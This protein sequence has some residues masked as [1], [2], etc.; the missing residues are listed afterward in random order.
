MADLRPFLTGFW[1]N[2][3]LGQE[4]SIS[5]TFIYNGL[6]SFYGL[7]KLD[8]T[9]E[10]FEVLYNLS[11]GIE[12]LMKI[13][14][15]LLEHKDSDDIDAFENSLRTHSHLELLGRIKKHVDVPLA[16][17]HHDF[18]ALLTKF[19]I[20]LRYDRFLL[21]SMR[22]LD[23]ERQEL[24]D[25]LEKHLK[26]EFG[27]RDSI[28]GY[29]N[30]PRYKKF[31]RGIV[32]KIS[33]ALYKVVENRAHELNVYTY[34]MR[35]GSKAETVFLGKADIPTEDVLWKELLIF[36]MNTTSTSGYLKFLR[37]IEPLSFDPALVGDYLDCFQ[38]DAAKAQV[39]DDLEARYE[40]VADKAGR[41]ET[42]AAIGSRNISFDDEDEDADALDNP[43]EELGK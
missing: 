24:F 19:Y 20:T 30:S 25:F 9:D 37:G 21:Q 39:V 29:E 14:V 5:G 35:S 12:R 18:L 6:R 33:S 26:A 36:L 27:D 28:L 22:V 15:V 10:I 3:K 16:G 17:P 32:T 40:D 2:F 13:V 7:R 8:H 41:L 23:S 42:M 4:L 34:E 43:D 31:I 38:S 1:K 11:V